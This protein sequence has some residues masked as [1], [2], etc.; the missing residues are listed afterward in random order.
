MLNIQP[1]QQLVKPLVPRHQRV[2]V[3]NDHADVRPPTDLAGVLF[4]DSPSR[5]SLII[6]HVPAIHYAK[7]LIVSWV[8]RLLATID[9]PGRGA[10]HGSEQFRMVEADPQR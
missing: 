9:N 4:Y 3:S 5:G 6:V 1:C 2:V 10:G 7:P 8:G